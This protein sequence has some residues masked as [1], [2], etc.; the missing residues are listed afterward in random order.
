ML[1]EVNKDSEQKRT[2]FTPFGSKPKTAPKE[3]SKDAPAAP[4]PRGFTAFIPSKAAA[5]A[6]VGDIA[7][8]TIDEADMPSFLLTDTL[9]P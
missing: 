7:V 3:A 1:S 6:P 5:P 8:E 9:K 4:A 2:M